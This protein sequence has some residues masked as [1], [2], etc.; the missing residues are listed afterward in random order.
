[1]DF[2]HTGD[3]GY[4]NAMGQFFIVDRK[5]DTIVVSGFKVYP[6]EIEDVVV[7]H[8]DVRE[9]AC[10]RVPDDKSGQA[11]K[12]FVVRNT[13]ELTMEAVRSYCRE[14]LTAYKVPKHYAFIDEIPKSN[15]GKI[16]RKE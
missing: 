2:L 3:I 10:I 5:D 14:H 16:L 4:R 7:T 11:V 8:P 15:V 13:P 6:T 1:D 12:L 9:T